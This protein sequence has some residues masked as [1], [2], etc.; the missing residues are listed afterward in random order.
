MREMIKMV[1]VLTFLSALSGG[2][3]AA[4]RDQTWGTI[5]NQRLK[6]V[7]GPAIAKIFPDASNDPIA[8]RFSVTD[9]KNE[10]TVFIGKLDGEAQA[11]FIEGTGKGYSGDV[12]LIVGI[13]LKS[14]QILGVGVTNHSESPGIG[15]RAKDEPHLAGEFKGRVLGADLRITTEGGVINAISGATIT[16]RGVCRAAMEAVNFYEN[17]Q[18]KIIAKTTER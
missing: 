4:A 9:G 17:N 2:L 16:S 3:L 10:K 6:F 5:E 15:S 11:I 1:L 18:S 8:D 12:G 7:K 13:D 14:N